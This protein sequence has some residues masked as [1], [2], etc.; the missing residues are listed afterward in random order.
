MQIVAKI[1]D[2]EFLANLT[3]PLM[4][5]VHNRAQSETG[6][7]YWPAVNFGRGPVFPKR[8][9]ALKIPIGGGRFIF[10]KSAGPAAPRYILVKT[11][12][13]IP[14]NAQFAATFAA[15]TNLRGWWASFLNAMAKLQA[16][17]L[18]EKTPFGPT[19]RLASSYEV[20]EAR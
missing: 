2:S 16:A 13:T 20:K 6:F 4:S 12:P 9:K 3:A 19:G 14:G 8:A 1:D 15:G 10:R 5:E 11:L 7:Y 17:A 18:A